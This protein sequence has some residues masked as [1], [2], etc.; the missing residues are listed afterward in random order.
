MK[1]H[2]DSDSVEEFDETGNQKQRRAKRF[3]N[4]KKD[5]RRFDRDDNELFDRKDGDDED[6]YLEY[7]QWSNKDE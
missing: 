2:R 1:W 7:L 4:K 5:R 6:D 3:Q